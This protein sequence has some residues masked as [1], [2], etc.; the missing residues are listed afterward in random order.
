MVKF[1]NESFIVTCN[2]RLDIKLVWL[3]NRGEVVAERK[4]RVHVEH[5]GG[6]WRPLG[7]SPVSWSDSECLLRSTRHMHCSVPRETLHRRGSPVPGAVRVQAQS[8]SGQGTSRDQGEG[9]Q[10]REAL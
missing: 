9:G 7:G 2:P 10:W 8:D 3:S 5:I 1:V 6:E 4:G